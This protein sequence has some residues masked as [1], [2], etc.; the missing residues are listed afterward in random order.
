MK[1]S[2]SII[3]CT[4]FSLLFVHYVRSDIVKRDISWNGNNWA[5]G[6]DFTGNDMSNV[7]IRGEDC[8]GKCAETSGCTHFAWN[9]WN[10]GTCWLKQG[11]ATKNDAVPADQDV[12]CGV[13]E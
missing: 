6:C 11:E 4:L 9:S 1:S 2:S 13:M 3:V 10:G 8:G 12:V 5:M 7:Q